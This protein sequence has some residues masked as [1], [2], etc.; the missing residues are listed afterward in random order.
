MLNEWLE[1]QEDGLR[2]ELR[3][4]LG[5]ILSGFKRQNETREGRL[6]RI[7][8]AALPLLYAGDDDLRSLPPDVR[9]CVRA[10]RIQRL[11]HELDTEP[12]PK[13]ISR[14]KLSRVK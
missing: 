2:E 11:L 14:P 3:R 8:K 13:K 12:S 7:K 6:W 4:G 5:I 10:L 9:D 1:K